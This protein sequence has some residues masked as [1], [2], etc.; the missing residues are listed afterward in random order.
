MSV[1]DGL[2]KESSVGFELR[3]LIYTWRKDL[4]SKFSTSPLSA[5]YSVDSPANSILELGP[6]N[7]FLE[8]VLLSYQCVIELGFRF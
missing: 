5:K 6:P 3:T 2:T 4:L 7:M 8:D 1:S